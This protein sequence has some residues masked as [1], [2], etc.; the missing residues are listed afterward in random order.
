M[1]TCRNRWRK[2]LQLPA[3]IT[4]DISE[5]LPRIMPIWMSSELEW[6]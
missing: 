2:K 5:E 4:D 1:E 3:D 6:L